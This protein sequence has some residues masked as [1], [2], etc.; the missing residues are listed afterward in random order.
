MKKRNLGVV[1][2]SIVCLAS[3]VLFL[4]YVFAAS[5]T[6]SIN[7]T[8]GE[9][10][11]YNNYTILVNNTDPRNNITQVNLTVSGTV[12]YFNI[13]SM[14]TNTTTNISNSSSAL[15]FTNNSISLIKNGTVG[16]FWLYA[17]T[18]QTG[19]VNI[20]IS[21]LDNNSAIVSSVVTVTVNDTVKPTISF[22]NQT[23][24]DTSTGLP[25]IPVNVT[26]SDSGSGIKNITVYLSNSS[27]LV[28]SVTNTTSFFYNFTGLSTATYYLWAIAFDNGN[29][30]AS[31]GNLTLGVVANSTS[32]NPNWVN[33]TGTCTNSTQLVTWS[34]SNNCNVTTGQP[35]AKNQSCSLN[36]SCVTSWACTDW[37]PAVCSSDNGSQT[38]T[39][40]DSNGCASPQVETRDCALG[41]AIT[42]NN[43]TSQTSA[44][45][46]SL[47]SAFFI[48]MGVIIV[49][50][51]G[52]VVILMRLRKKSYSTDF[53]SSKDSGGYKSFPPRGPP[54]GPS[55]FPSSQP[56]YRPQ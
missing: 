24:T 44:T 39:C 42:T 4:N 50:V 35:A 38:R 12:S 40:T 28:N 22:V 5:Q 25:N 32:C 9:S 19:I 45:S 26:T 31:T 2:L 1:I 33:S 37:T 48:V 46:F 47:S 43:S 52:V 21:S 16:L 8:T 36:A 56:A 49:S 55:G 13:G 3:L 53:G 30:N 34:D 41:S 10:G 29:N 18:N 23:P 27:G 17:M 54:S 11:V 7:P 15:V 20:T 14:G 6:A 51:V